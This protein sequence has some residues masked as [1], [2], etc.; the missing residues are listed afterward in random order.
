MTT[1]TIETINIYLILHY[2]LNNNKKTTSIAKLKSFFFFLVLFKENF[3]SI[4]KLHR[5]PFNKQS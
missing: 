5:L 4:N 3:I 2:F 1:I